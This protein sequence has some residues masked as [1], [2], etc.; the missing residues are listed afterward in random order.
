MTIFLYVIK[1]DDTLER[2]RLE[3]E[4]PVGDYYGG[5]D[6]RQQKPDLSSSRD[7]GKIM[8]GGN[9]KGVICHDI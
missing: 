7:R 2:V 1:T 4:E 6:E 9:I 8:K 3:A 5:P